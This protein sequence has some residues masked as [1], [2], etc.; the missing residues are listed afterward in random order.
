MVARA[1]IDIHRLVAAAEQRDERGF[2]RQA[3]AVV[4]DTNEAAR[5]P[6]GHVDADGVHVQGAVDLGRETL[7]ERPHG[8]RVASVVNQRAKDPLGVVLLAEEAAVHIGQQP[9]T[10]PQQA[11]AGRHQNDEYELPAP[12]QYL[13][14]RLPA[15]VVEKPEQDREG[16]GDQRQDR[17]ARQRVANRAAHD[18]AYAEHLA[19]IHR[20]SRRREP[21]PQDRIEDQPAP[22]AWQR[23]AHERAVACDRR[24]GDRLRQNRPGAQ[25]QRPHEQLGTA[26][27]GPA[28]RAHVDD[29]Q[30]EP[31]E[32]EDGVQPPQ[33]V[34]A[35]HHEQ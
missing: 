35:L 12:A 9:A 28:R 19:G 31:G 15:L 26:P 29:D 4:I 1:E 21:G 34:R 3:I 14:Q 7:A 11:Q 13:R 6:V 32:R 33:S 18:E 22:H 5:P 23:L 27:I 17:G 8:V 10:D 20:I 30:D 2:G 25:H 16:H 24:F